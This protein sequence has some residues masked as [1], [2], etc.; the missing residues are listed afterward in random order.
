MFT[1]NCVILC[2]FGIEYIF[3]SSKLFRDDVD[4]FDGG[5]SQILCERLFSSNLA[6]VLLSFLYYTCFNIGPGEKA[7]KTLGFRMGKDGNVYFIVID[8]VTRQCNS[9]DLCYIPYA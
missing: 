8:H 2:F 4:A 7:G 5:L 1:L 6:F 3:S 9:F